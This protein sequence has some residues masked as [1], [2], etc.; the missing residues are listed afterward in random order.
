MIIVVSDLHLAAYARGD[1]TKGPEDKE[2]KGDKTGKDDAQFL[3][4]LKYLSSHQLQNGGDLVLLGDA[5]DY[6]RRGLACALLD[7][8]GAIDLLRSLKLNQNVGL[9]YVVGNHDYYNWNLRS[10]VKSYYPFDDMDKQIRLNDGDRDFFFI[11]GH[12]IE[13]MVN[14]YYNSLE[15]YESFSEQLCLAGQYFGAHLA[16]LW[17]LFTYCANIFQKIFKRGLPPDV[18]KT[19]ESMSKGP[20]TRLYGEH[21]AA[22]SIRNLSAERKIL[23]EKFGLKEDEFLIFG[24]THDPFFSQNSMVINAGSWN[25]EPCELYLFLQIEEGEPK[26]KK[27]EYGKCVEIQIPAQAAERSI[28]KAITNTKPKDTSELGMEP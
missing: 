22:K 5:V 9:H 3:E 20:E 27:F 26:F 1:G 6:W 7:S 24:H 10:L 17:D 21:T 18:S 12:Q 23:E 25:K 16:G 19:L 4:F 8:T 2:S 15:I 13:M 28:K 11:H 14:P